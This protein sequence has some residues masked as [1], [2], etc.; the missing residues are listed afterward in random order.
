MT[1]DATHKTDGWL[2]AVLRPAGSLDT[3]RVALLVQALTALAASSDMLIVD[4]TAT[5]VPDPQQLAMAL[6]GPAQRFAAPEKCLLLVG[7]SSDVLRSLTRAGDGP[8]AW[9]TLL[10]R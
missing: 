3:S 2:T 10:Q 1:V 8:R 7:G 9:R 4:L 5:T 6:R